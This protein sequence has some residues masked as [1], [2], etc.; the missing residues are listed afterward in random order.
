MSYFV[1]GATGFIGRNMVKR[2]LERGDA[3]IYILI[4]E[5]SL[6][7]LDE[8]KAQL[9]GASERVIPVV[10]DLTQPALGVSEQDRAMLKGKVQH[11]FHLAAVYDLKASAESQQAAN[12]DGTRHAVQ[13]AEAIDA[14]CFHLVS[15]I[16]AAGLYE[17]TFREDMFEEA[18]NLSHPYFRTKHDSEAIVR[19]EC[20]IAWRVYRPGIVVGHSE[21]GEID[22]IDGPYYF[23]KLIQKLRRMLPPWMPAIGLDGSRINIVPVDFVVKAMDHIA[24]LPGYDGRCFHLTDPEPYKLGEIL[25]I[26]TKAAHA[27]RF[28]V[29]LNPALFGF[30]PAV[31]RQG[32]MMLTPVR[33]IRDAVMKDLGLPSDIMKFVN[34]PTR[35]DN[36][37]AMQL[38]KPAGIKVPRL[39]DYAWRLWDYWERHLDPDLHIDRSLAG[40][41]KG[42]IV[43][44]TGGS[45][46]IGEAA[47]LKIAQAGAT[48][49]IVARD[50]EKLAVTKQQI[51]AAGGTAFVYSCDLSDLDAI[52]GLAKQVLA[53]HGGVDVL[54]NN[55]GRSI[56]RGIELSYDRFH[57]FQ[58]TM[59]LNYFGS[60]RLTLGLLPSMVERRK[61]HVINLSSIGVLT[62]APRFSA[63]VASKAALDAFT[64]CAASE[65]SDKGIEFTT[66][67]MP[68]VKTAMTAPTKIYNNVPMISPE[69][70][71]DF[72]AQ[73]II[74]KPQRIATKLGIF[75]QVLH[76][77]APKMTHVIM[78]TS[79]RM[80][81]ESAAALGKKDGEVQDVTPDQLAM[82]QLMKGIHM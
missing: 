36:R 57:D 39:E 15:S 13:L 64:R 73:A 47:A 55:A 61:G 26:L 67:N 29:R 49:L 23:F 5:S 35:F 43:M 25:E 42:K 56:R 81:P 65:F 18:E 27:P 28:A 12:V 71:A 11:F 82:M 17:G 54:I 1:T 37:D 62:N 52:D 44:I 8:L 50:M 80:F 20:K 51:E 79:Y 21:T 74:H 59:Q 41:V 38:L 7:K 76:A 72:I 46:G 33:R 48:V 34:Y 68:L 10:G 66:I 2:L 3:P 16:A 75:A 40:S 78:N 45:S 14:G 58:R 31:V 19:K 77:I 53:D 6:S 69:E 60:L 70:A 32:M 9:G 22:K 24:H 4:R 63:Y 30:I